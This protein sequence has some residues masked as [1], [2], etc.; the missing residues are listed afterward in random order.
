MSP[1]E[2]NEA[3]KLVQ[4]LFSRIAT[5]RGA[6]Q[7]AGDTIS[8]EEAL[9]LIDGQASMDVIERAIRF[10]DLDTPESHGQRRS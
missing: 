7:S 9:R 4:E 6:V 3:I 5:I 2:Q 8:A 10:L 1:K